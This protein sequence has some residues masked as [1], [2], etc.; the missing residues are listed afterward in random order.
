MF[1][2]KQ[3][4][5]IWNSLIVKILSYAH[6]YKYVELALDLADPLNNK[7]TH[8]I[9]ATIIQTLSHLIPPSAFDQVLQFYKF[10]CNC[11]QYEL[12]IEAANGLNKIS[13]LIPG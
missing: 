5:G 11:H 4:D 1:N 2:K 10:I 3:K 6:S 7:S 9:A 13:K 12:R 8:R